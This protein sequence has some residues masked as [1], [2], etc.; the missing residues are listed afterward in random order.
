MALAKQQSGR[1]QKNFEELSER[2]K[3]S[4]SDDGAPALTGESSALE[5]LKTRKAIWIGARDK[6]ATPCV[7]GSMA[8]SRT[9]MVNVSDACKDSAGSKQHARH[10]GASAFSTSLEG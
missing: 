1:V 7:E 8:W 6:E 2:K 9:S 5:V 4:C 10:L 3:A